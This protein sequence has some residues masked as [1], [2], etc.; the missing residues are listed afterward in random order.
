[1]V[2]SRA[3]AQTRRA[4]YNTSVREPVPRGKRR[5]VP[6]LSLRRAATT[7]AAV[8]WAPRHQ[9]DKRECRAARRDIFRSRSSRGL[10][11]VLWSDWA[12]DRGRERNRSLPL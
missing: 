10:L 6:R 5:R 8:T 4:L 3:K 1:M 7:V 9:D 12:N 2:T 11:F